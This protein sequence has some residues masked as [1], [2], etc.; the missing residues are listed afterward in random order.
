MGRV[1][2]EEMEGPATSVR[3]RAVDVR[4]GKVR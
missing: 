3:P 1:G 4:V 2:V